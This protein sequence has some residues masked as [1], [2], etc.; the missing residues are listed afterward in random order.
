[1]VRVTR[2]GLSALSLILGVMVAVAVAGCSE[3][4]QSGKALHAPAT[5]DP[6]LPGWVAC[7]RLIL[8]GDVIRVSSADSPG[9]MVTELAV[10]EWIKPASGPKV[11]TIE[12]PDIAAEGVYEWW[13][14]GTHL[15]L[16]VDVDP[17]ALPNWQFRDRTIKKIKRA[18]PAS[19]TID[20]PYG[21]A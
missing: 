3:Q 9:H 18:V 20:C 15:F 6:S 21:P 12:T 13:K 14:P 4:E 7:S 2:R 19:R 5:F 17:A 1:M 16:Q 11:A 8:E 10:D